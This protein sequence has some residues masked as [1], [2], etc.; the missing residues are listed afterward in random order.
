MHTQ[1]SSSAD[2]ATYLFAPGADDTDSLAPIQQQL[3]S[4]TS[5][6]APT[7]DDGRNGTIRRR[8]EQLLPIGAQTLRRVA[9]TG[10]ETADAIR[11]RRDELYRNEFPRLE[12]R[13]AVACDA[14]D[15]QFDAA[16][17]ND[18]CPACGA[19][20]L[21]EPDPAQE[22]RAKRQFASIN[23]EGQSLRD[24]AKRAEADQWVTGVSTLVIKHEYQ[25]ATTETVLY[26]EGEIY[27]VEP[28][29]IYRADPL[30]V[31]PRTDDKGRPGGAWACP[32]HRDEVV[33]E[34]PGRCRCGADLR[35][36]WFVELGG[37]RTGGEG[38]HTRYFR[39][40]VI[41]WSYAHPRLRGL[42]GIAPAAHIWLKQT[43]LEMMDRWGGAYYNQSND[44]LPSK[45][46]LVHTTNPDGFEQA[47][48]QARDDQ[49]RYKQSVLTTALDPD[50]VE[51]TELDGMP[52]EL[53]GQ[54]EE[55]KSQFKSDIR[56][57]F[58]ISDVHDSDL[59]D[60]GG[61]NNEGL[62]L[63][64]VDRSLASQMLDYRE[65][66]L[67][68]LMKR[69][70]FGDWQISFLPDRGSDADALR[71]NLKAA[72]FVKQ[73]GGSA[74]IVDGELHVEDFEVDLDDSD[75]PP[76]LQGTPNLP[77]VGSPVPDAGGGGGVG[78]GG[79][80]GFSQGAAQS[81]A[82]RPG[83]D[84]SA[85]RGELRALEQAAFGVRG[86]N[87][88]DGRS[89]IAQQGAPVY[90]SREDVP[91]NV[92]R[93]IADAVRRND[94]RT[95][96]DAPSARLEQFFETKLTQPQGWSIDSLA[97]GLRERGL[98]ES[99]NARTAARTESAAILS[100]ARED[101]AAELAATV[102]D[103]VLHYWDG[104]NDNDVTETCRWLKQQTNPEF[105]GTPVPMDELRDLQKEAI[106]RFS[107]QDP[108]ATA[109][110]DHVL[111]A[112]ERHTHRAVLASEI[113]S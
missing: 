112:Q 88:A 77:G 66:W 99:E 48:T 40:E 6:P 26:R 74:E 54:S 69:L 56:Q 20:D 22:R 31:R 85:L 50:N 9:L 105:D 11:T 87:I 12:P 108:G 106:R 76:S 113:D 27:R 23:P 44:R 111:H 63:E 67:D 64:V 103:D 17:D 86:V 39:E 102:D 21:R 68:T 24:V 110:R 38:T 61:L 79:G 36:V 47:V 35:E 4:A 80:P 71:D 97:T 82:G 3:T 95:I 7:S 18:V 25:Q 13:F 49:D 92:Q 107:D 37:G 34:E 41:T 72:A 100:R 46:Y 53:L 81:G 101:A 109:V 28:D 42:D 98:V 16:P 32:I 57:A 19:S 70:G 91:P 15:A 5:T 45:M 73:A 96:E 55:M 94:F 30:A 90:A 43:I 104:P 59:T 10:A 58:G 29:A 93:R 1:L 62:Q 33:R 14:C 84:F 60:A 75:D 78:A 65:G 2:G 89:A 83:A 51:I 52:D 8:T